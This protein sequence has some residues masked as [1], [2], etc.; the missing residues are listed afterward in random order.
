VEEPGSA[1]FAEV[2]PDAAAGYY[3]VSGV[4]LVAFFSF[5]SSSSGNEIES[6][7][8]PAFFATGYDPSTIFISKCVFLNL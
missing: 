3:L 1:P 2:R 7:G 5:D 4:V 8:G 6:P